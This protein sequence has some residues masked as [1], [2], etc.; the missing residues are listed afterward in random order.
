[1]RQENTILGEED[2]SAAQLCL[3]N[4]N[5]QQSSRMGFG[6]ARASAAVRAGA[7]SVQVA[8]G[9]LS[10]STPIFGALQCSASMCPFD[11]NLLGEPFLR[12]LSLSLSQPSP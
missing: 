6:G 2:G 8:R 3:S 10:F 12:E 4:I 5:V 7:S 9:K 11:G 1:M